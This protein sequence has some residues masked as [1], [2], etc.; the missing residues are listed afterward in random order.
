MFCC[1]I[2]PNK[3]HSTRAERRWMSVNDMNKYDE[4]ERICGVSKGMWGARS[5]QNMEVKECDSA[6]CIDDDDGDD[7]FDVGASTVVSGTIQIPTVRD[8]YNFQTGLII[9]QEYLQEQHSGIQ[10]NTTMA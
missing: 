6:L 3:E 8:R 5:Q 9:Q 1:Y 2:D 10:A 4:Q 7:F